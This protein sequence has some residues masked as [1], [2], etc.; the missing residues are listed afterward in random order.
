MR[1]LLNNI[2][3]LYTLLLINYIVWSI[4]KSFS[5]SEIIWLFFPPAQPVWAYYSLVI[6][7]DLSVTLC[8][9]SSPILFPNCYLH[10]WLN[11]LIDGFIDWHVNCCHGTN[12]ETNTKKY[13][14]EMLFPLYAFCPFRFSDSFYSILKGYV[15]FLLCQQGAD[16]KGYKNLA[17]WP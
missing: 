13:T 4:P 14:E 7:L 9:L 17:L 15:Y 16:W 2:Q 11:W 1:N 8:I 12:S 3:Y 6:E 10:T 5:H